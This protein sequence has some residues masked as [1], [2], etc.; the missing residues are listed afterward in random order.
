MTLERTNVRRRVLRDLLGVGGLVASD[1]LTG[2]SRAVGLSNSARP[3]LQLAA[4][5]EALSISFYTA[6]LRDASFH[7]GVSATATLQQVLAT[8]TDHQREVASLGGVP[9]V[10]TFYV[11]PE[12]QSDAR[13]FVRTAQHLSHLGL[14]VYLSATE[15]LALQGR[16]SSAAVAARL[17]ASEAQHAVMLVHLAGLNTEPSAVRVAVQRL[18]TLTAEIAPYLRPHSSTSLRLTFGAG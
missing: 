12:V 7:M 8:K 18:E 16:S 1:V 15:A 9:S 13:Q 5:T 17:A 3:L 11:S 14:Q 4:V 6:V 10:S 2:G